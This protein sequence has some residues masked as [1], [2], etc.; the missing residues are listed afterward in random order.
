M[1]DLKQA[2][3]RA[4]ESVSRYNRA[5]VQPE[6]FQREVKARFGDRRCKATWVKA[7]AYFEAQASYD[8]CLDAYML[9]LHTF[10]FTPERWDYEYRHEIL[11]AFLM[12]PEGLELIRAGL[13]QL[14]SS[15]FTQEERAEAN[16]FFELV[17]ERGGESGRERLPVGLDRRINAAHTA[18]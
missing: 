8:A 7:L 12:M 3:Y 14:F 2:T 9:V 10:N 18:A 11:D 4:W 15:D 16:G 6:N 5:V 17:E 1:Q 13:E